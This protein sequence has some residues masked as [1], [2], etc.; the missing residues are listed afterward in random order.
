V[1][2]R[3]LSH[4]LLKVAFQLLLAIGDKLDN[5]EQLFRKD[6][7]QAFEI[8]VFGDALKNIENREG[9]TS[10]PQTDDEHAQN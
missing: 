9:W 1:D 7:S 6:I 8:V 2:N 3:E 10:Q 4:R 5:N